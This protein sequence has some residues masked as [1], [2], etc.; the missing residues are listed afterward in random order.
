[1]EGHRTVTLGREGDKSEVRVSKPSP[2]GPGLVSDGP[3]GG[4]EAHLRAVPPGG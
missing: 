4:G 1:M 2:W 3:P